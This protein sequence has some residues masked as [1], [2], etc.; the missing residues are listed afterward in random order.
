MVALCS[1]YG[2]RLAVLL[3][4]ACSMSACAGWLGG[5]EDAMSDFEDSCEDV[6]WA[7]ATASQSYFRNRKL[8][9]EEGLLFAVCTM[10]QS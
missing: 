8:V 10:F 5:E 1:R 7:K 2:K 9:A 4:T 6:V 3:L